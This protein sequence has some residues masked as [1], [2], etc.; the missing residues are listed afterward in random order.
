[1]KDDSPVAEVAP[2]LGSTVAEARGGRVAGRP[3][4]GADAQV[5]RL[6]HKDG[7]HNRAAAADAR[8][9]AREIARRSVAELGREWQWLRREDGPAHGEG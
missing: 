4:C 8:G 3:A 1:M 7:A 5:G 6:G 9:D 2:S